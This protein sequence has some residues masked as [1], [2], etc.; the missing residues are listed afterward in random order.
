MSQIVYIRTRT[1]SKCFWSV[2]VEIYIPLMSSRFQILR[3]RNLESS[4]CNPE[5]TDCLRFTYMVQGGMGLGGGGGK[6]YCED[7]NQRLP[8]AAFSCSLW[9]PFQDMT[10]RGRAAGCGMVFCPFALN[11][12]LSQGLDPIRGS[13]IWHA[14]LASIYEQSQIGGLYLNLFKELLVTSIH[15]REP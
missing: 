2:T 14:R 6:A 9:Q 10:L 7:T 13:M 5:S 1:R 4:T 8:R 12:E 3:T 15:F 11:C